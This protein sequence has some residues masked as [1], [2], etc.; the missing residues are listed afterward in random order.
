MEIVFFHFSAEAENLFE[1]VV[2]GGVLDRISGCD[3]AEKGK[4]KLPT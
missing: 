3:S 4:K 1:M 2:K